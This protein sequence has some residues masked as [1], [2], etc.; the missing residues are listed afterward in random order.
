MKVLILS[1]VLPPAGGAEKVAWDIAGEYAK[2]HEV[3][4]FVMGKSD[5]VITKKNITIHF[6]EQKVHTLRYYLTIGKKKIKKR[7]KKIN[8]DLIHAHAPT[9]FA[10]ILRN[11]ECS[12]IISFHNSEIN[13][14]N[15]NFF[16]R[17]KV[18]F[19]ENSCV[20][21]YKHLTTVSSHMNNYFHKKYHKIFSTI[22]NGIDTN[23][24]YNKKFVRIPNSII[25][26]GQLSKAKGVDQLLKI[27]KGLK[28][29]KF[30]IIGE[31]VL[32][33]SVDLPNVTFLGRKN[34]LEISDLL[35]KSEFAIFPSIYENFPLVGLEAMGCGVITIAS[36]TGFGEYIKN[37]YNGFLFE[38]NNI[39]QVFQILNS[40]IDN[41]IRK[42][43][44]NTIK[45]YSLESISKR[46][47]NL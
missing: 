18:H 35:N 45:N 2:N 15:Y 29:Y 6:F 37:G 34:S 21:S 40:K 39:E 46:Y 24:F 7:A 10:Y 9:I 28:T 5:E 19:F 47:L 16:R 26:V 31:G 14:Y 12:N 43:A 32:K 1:I 38:V 36:N 13:K 42:N 8:P 11:W 25:Y 41:N 33:N 20:K 44:C 27:A 3:H 30:T 4:I 17:I 23:V 22:E